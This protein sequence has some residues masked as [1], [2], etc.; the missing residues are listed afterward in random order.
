MQLVSSVEKAVDELK[1][2][3]HAFKVS[4]IAVMG[5]EVNGPGEACDADIGIAGAANH[6][7]ILFKN[8]RR[9]ATLEANE[10]LPAL[11]KS[12]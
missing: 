9:I 6:K 11:L 12:L 10:L 2:A 7:G 4:R 5:C 1:A 8:G 3:G